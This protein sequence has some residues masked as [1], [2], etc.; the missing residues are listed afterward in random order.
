MTS[1]AGVENGGLINN[2]DGITFS[3]VTSV[4]ETS[5]FAI[6]YALQNKITEKR[7]YR[8]NYLTALFQNCL[9]YAHIVP[10]LVHGKFFQISSNLVD[11]K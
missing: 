4:L 2:G 10:F 9:D 11:G 6:G 3:Y 7:L 1:T 5:V 8:K